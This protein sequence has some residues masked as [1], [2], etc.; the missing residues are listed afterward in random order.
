MYECFV[1]SSP[2]NF[3]TKN[4][5]PKFLDKFDTLSWGAKQ[6]YTLLLEEMKVDKFYKKPKIGTIV[7]RAYGLVVDINQKTNLY[8]EK[9]R[10]DIAKI[11][12]KAIGT[13]RKYI[14]ELLAHGLI[15]DIKC[16]QGH[17][18]KIFLK[19]PCD[20][21]YTYDQQQLDNDFDNQLE[22]L[23]TN[24]K[25]DTELADSVPPDAPSEVDGINNHIRDIVSHIIPER[26]VGKQ[27]KN[28][29]FIAKGK[30]DQEK[31]E[32]IQKAVQHCIGKQPKTTMFNMLCDALKMEW[33][34][35]TKPKVVIV[36]DDPPLTPNPKQKKKKKRS[37]G[38]GMCEHDFDYEK[39]AD[40]EQQHVEKQLSDFHDGLDEKEKEKIKNKYQVDF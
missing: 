13:I 21:E 12:E 31:L 15:L 9:S 34:N 29:M 19:F 5:M 38:A 33:Y 2:T 7:K 32:N 27:C 17:Y 8:I 40:L 23:N 14:K 18:N 39:L 37:F 3:K 25:G 22:K 35:K 30:T 26:L 36:P 20:A 6:V 28:L 11:M 16:G 24:E 4:A 10:K 1:L